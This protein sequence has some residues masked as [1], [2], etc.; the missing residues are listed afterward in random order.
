MKIL[1][2]NGTPILRSVFDQETSG[3]LPAKFIKDCS[4]QTL[5]FG[6]SIQRKP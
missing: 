1:I 5:I 2:L 4:Q 3:E 6:Y